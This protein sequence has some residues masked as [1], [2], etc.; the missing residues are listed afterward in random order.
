MPKILTSF[1]FSLVLI[2][3]EQTGAFCE[4]QNTG[5]IGH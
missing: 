3:K 4:D 2:F 1:F 5:L